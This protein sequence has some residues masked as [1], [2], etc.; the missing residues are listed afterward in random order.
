[1]ITYKEFSKI[2][3]EKRILKGFS[4][5]EFSIMLTINVSKLNKIENGKQ[6][7]SF[8]ELELICQYLNINLSELFSL[9]VVI[10]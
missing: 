9:W 3:K 1:M 5:K 2:I 7:P 6:E 10:F 4:Q 8:L